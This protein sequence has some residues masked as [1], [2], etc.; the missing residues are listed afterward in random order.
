[1]GSIVITFETLY[2]LL[3]REKYRP[4]LQ[5]LDKSFFDDVLRYLT[6]KNSIL[7]AMETRQSIFSGEAQKTRR[8][9]ESI[10]KILNDLYEKRENKIL[11]LAIFSSR[12]KDK[13]VHPNLLNEEQQFYSELLMLLNKYRKGILSNILS[14]KGPVIENGKKE[15]AETRQI[16]FQHHVPRFV[17]DDL[18]VYGPFKEGDIANLSTKVAALL[19]AEKRA[20]DVKI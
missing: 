6:E 2:E 1:M 14:L 4:E 17:G 18:K 3:R 5:Q 7:S 11:Q 8:Q 19:V 12:L 16:R 10:K 9:F 13:N 20:V 15:G